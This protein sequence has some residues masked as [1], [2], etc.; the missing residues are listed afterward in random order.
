MMQ[1]NP[2]FSSEDIWRRDA[3][4]ALDEGRRADAER[5]THAG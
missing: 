4:I 2:A 1:D 5:P 3:T